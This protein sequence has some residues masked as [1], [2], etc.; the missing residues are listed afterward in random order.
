MP[1]L[2]YQV[3]DTVRSESRPHRGFGWSVLP[4]ICRPG[5]PQDKRSLNRP[6]V[7]NDDLPQLRLIGEVS[8]PG[9]V[10]E[11]V[12]EQPA[13]LAIPRAT[14]AEIRRDLV[15]YGMLACVV[16]MVVSASGLVALVGQLF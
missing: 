2:A 14:E 13:P 1:S 12:V 11:H 7:A 8:S 4:L 15:A 9:S 6:E 5:G 16:T 10:H 3:A